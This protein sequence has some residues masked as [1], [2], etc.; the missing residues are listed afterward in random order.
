[1]RRNSWHPSKG[2]SADDRPV[3]YR[4]IDCQQIVTRIGVVCVA[5]GGAWGQPEQACL[6]LSCMAGRPRGLPASVTE[7][8]RHG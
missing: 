5:A 6:C 3:R 8:A 1:M 2:H 4:C 7:E